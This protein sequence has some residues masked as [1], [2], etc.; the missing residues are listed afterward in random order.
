MYAFQKA[1]NTP[2]LKAEKPLAGYCNIQNQERIPDLYFIRGGDILQI[3]VTIRQDWGNY[4]LPD[5][6]GMPT[7]R[8]APR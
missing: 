7:G 6:T 5:Q 4:F 3:C 1:L 2:P 8:A